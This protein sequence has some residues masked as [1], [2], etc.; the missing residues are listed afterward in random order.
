MHGL[1]RAYA[2]QRYEELTGWKSP[3]AGGSTAKTL[4]S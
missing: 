3:A 4:I 2:Q 1:H